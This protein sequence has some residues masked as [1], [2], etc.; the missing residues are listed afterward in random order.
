[1]FEWTPGEGDDEVQ[2][3]PRHYI[4]CDNDEGVIGRL[5]CSV[6]LYEGRWREIEYNSRRQKF[7]VKG[8]LM[9]LHGFDKEEPPRPPSPT[10][11]DEEEDD[12]N[13]GYTPY[14]D[15][16][17]DIRQRPIPDS[18]KGKEK[19]TTQTQTSTRTEA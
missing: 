19:M 4:Y 10:V 8:E 11:E 2:G 3:R 6:T 12:R 7:E 5:S 18:V 13:S 14:A 16:T 1:M 9:F 17:A 15:V